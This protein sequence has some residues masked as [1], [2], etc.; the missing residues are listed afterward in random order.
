MTLEAIGAFHP[1]YFML[2]FALSS[3]PIKT[4]GAARCNALGI[5]LVCASC[6]Q[7]ITLRGKRK[8]K[9]HTTQR[10]EK[11]PGRFVVMLQI[12]FLRLAKRS[13][14]QSKKE[15]SLVLPSFF[16]S[17]V[18]MFFCCLCHP[19]PISLFLSALMVLTL[20]KSCQA[21]FAFLLPSSVP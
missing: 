21:V 20:P 15:V 5:L 11:P 1:S 17:V 16:V 9:E 6:W 4:C 2:C 19:R 13:R 3:C 12:R 18:V 8:E 14:Y 7:C 10:G